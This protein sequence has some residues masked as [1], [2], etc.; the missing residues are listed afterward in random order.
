LVRKKL[1]N[2]GEE[3]RTIKSEIIPLISNS[4]LLK[5]LKLDGRKSYSIFL[6]WDQANTPAGAIYGQDALLLT[7]NPVTNSQTI[8]LET[9]MPQLARWMILSIDDK[10][11]L[12]YTK[13]FQG[14]CNVGPRILQ[15]EQLEI[16]LA[17]VWGKI[18]FSYER[19]RKGFDLITKWGDSPWANTYGKLLY[20]LVSKQIKGRQDI[21]GDFVVR[22]G[23]LCAEILA[24][25]KA[26]TS[27]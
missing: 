19:D 21:N 27:P 14:L 8:K 6:I 2:A 13:Q 22:A 23:N 15:A 5:F 1:S 9:V 26:V 24:L 7:F 17:D 18:M 4:K 12:N 10:R 3:D 25:V 20:P 11:K 16:P